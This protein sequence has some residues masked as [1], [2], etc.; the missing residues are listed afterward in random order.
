MSEFINAYIELAGPAV[1]LG[2]AAGA[3]TYLLFGG[4][5][6]RTLFTAGGVGVVAGMLVSIVLAAMG[7]TVSNL[8]MIAAALFGIA[9]GY[10][11]GSAK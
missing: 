4:R 1:L 5:D 10:R 3:I 11:M 8:P 9:G 6:M 2:L 7:T